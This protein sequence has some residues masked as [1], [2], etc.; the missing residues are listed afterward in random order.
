MHSSLVRSDHLAG[1]LGTSASLRERA[2]TPVRR[3]LTGPAP[4]TGRGALGIF[5]PTE[6]RCRGAALIG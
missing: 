4:S 1:R 3:S 5:G 6:E 2:R